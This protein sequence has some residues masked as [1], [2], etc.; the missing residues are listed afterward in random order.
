MQDSLLKIL[1]DWRCDQV[2][3]GVTSLSACGDVGGGGAVDLRG[4]KIG[5]CCDVVLAML[6]WSSVLSRCSCVMDVQSTPMQQRD[7]SGVSLECVKRHRLITARQPQSCSRGTKR[8]MS[9]IRYVTF[10]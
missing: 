5:E 2:S 10:D 4:T 9:N 8:R 1:V 3:R 7:K 6:L